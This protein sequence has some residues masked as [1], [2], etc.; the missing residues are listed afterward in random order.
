MANTNAVESLAPEIGKSI[1]HKSAL[2]IQNSIRPFLVKNEEILG[3]FENKMLN[4]EAVILTAHR[5]VSIKYNGVSFT[6]ELL[7]KRKDIHITV[8][9]GDGIFNHDTYNISSETDGKSV[10]Y[11]TVNSYDVDK[12]TKLIKSMTHDKNVT[13]IVGSTIVVPRQENKQNDKT[14]ELASSG[15][16]PK[17]SS[18]RLQAVHSTSNRGFDDTNAIGGCCLFGPVGL[19]CGLCGSGQKQEKFYRMCL[20]CG[21]K[22]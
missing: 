17:C 6:K 2:K 20:N 1:K 10:Q 8:Q 9:A 18:D 5:L 12:I 4:T 21:H 13:T 16:C 11:A 3:I 14:S 19:L 7:L 22:F 15:Q